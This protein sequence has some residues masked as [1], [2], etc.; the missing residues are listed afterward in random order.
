MGF[1]FSRE[2]LIFTPPKKQ[3][4]YIFAGGFVWEKI[5]IGGLDLTHLEQMGMFSLASCGCLN[6]G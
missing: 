4:V 5:K 6:W 3:P 2:R 1:F